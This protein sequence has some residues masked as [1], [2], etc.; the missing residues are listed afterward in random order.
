MSNQ[1]QVRAQKA[2]AARL[3]ESLGAAPAP[4][5]AVVSE[6]PTVTEVQEPSQTIAELS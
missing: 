6:T 4:I 2:A 1:N 5:E 3:A